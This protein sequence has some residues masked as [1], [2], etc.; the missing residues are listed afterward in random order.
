MH[1]SPSTTPKVD[2]PEPEILEALRVVAEP[3]ALDRSHWPGDSVVMRLAPDEVLVVGA[4]SA[5]IADPHAVIV[6][7]HGFCSVELPRE[8]FDEWFSRESSWPLPAGEPAFAQGEV[9]GLPV[10]IHL[11]GDRVLIVTRSS[12]RHELEARL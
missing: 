7:E 2:V 1:R 9:A 6:R 4:E 11:D 8:V 12:L 3:D 5:S 10:K